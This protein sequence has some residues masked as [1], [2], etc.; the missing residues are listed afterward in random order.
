[1][2]RKASQ[3]ALS[4]LTRQGKALLRKDSDASPTAVTG[5][6]FTQSLTSSDTQK[7]WY[8]EN[9]QR[10]SKG[11]DHC[12]T[13]QLMFANASAKQIQGVKYSAPHYM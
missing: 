8:N 1:M 6:L 4:S 11:S 12:C 10:C 7:T 9:K 13:M 5:S 3:A 2:A